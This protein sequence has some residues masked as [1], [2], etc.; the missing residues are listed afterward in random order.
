[1][2]YGTI[3]APGAA[4]MPP[5]TST[6]IR[7]YAKPTQSSARRGWPSPTC[8][9]CS[10]GEPRINQF[11]HGARHPQK[12]T[13]SAE[14]NS[15][16]LA[17]PGQSE[18]GAPRI[19]VDEH[20]PRAAAA[21]VPDPRQFPAVQNQAACAL[22]TRAEGQL[23]GEIQHP[24]VTCVKVGQAFVAVEAGEL[25]QVGRRAETLAPAIAAPEGSRTDP[26]RSLMAEIPK[27]VKHPNGRKPKCFTL[28][29]GLAQE[30]GLNCF[31]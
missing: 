30:G 20:R 8:P 22:G 13:R 15:S 23:P 24:V 28:D 21:H 9:L 25:R 5:G 12:E 16:G 17:Q 27:T 14:L 31:P 11:S 1:M 3:P 26:E 6:S 10:T 4:G 7:K 29:G 19:A 18:A 2:K